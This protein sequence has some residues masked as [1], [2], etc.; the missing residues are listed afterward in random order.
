[1][2]AATRDFD[3]LAEITA[4]YARYSR[5]AGGLSSV[6][7]GVLCLAAFSVGALAPLPPALRYALAC[8]PLAWI[9]SKE[10]LRRLYYQRDGAVA[11]LID[12]RHAR[13]RRFMMIYLGAVA[14]F[15]IGGLAMQAG[16]AVLTWPLIG[17][18]AVVA[19]LPLVAWRWFWSVPDFLIGVL[20]I[21]QSAVLLAG[22]NYTV[23][24]IAIA[25]AFST[26]AIVGG[27][28]EH[29]DYLA[30]RDELGRGG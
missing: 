15:V 6:I 23:G 29:R 1:M 10:L 8:A 24:W 17:Y 20:L 25:L 21:C 28:R 27:W 18:V 2:N 9:A 13:L 4:R 26:I 14:A 7:G 3:R 12:A 19:S 11:E 22:R 30:L 16:A 5:S